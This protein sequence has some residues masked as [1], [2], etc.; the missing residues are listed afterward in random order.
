MHYGTVSASNK[1]IKKRFQFL[2]ERNRM[3]NLLGFYEQ[4]TI[5]KVLPLLCFNI[6]TNVAKDAAKTRWKLLPDLRAYVWVM[7]HPRLIMEKRRKI[8][9]I[10][11]VGDDEITPHMS[12]KL[13]SE[14]SGLRGLNGLSLAYCRVLGIRTMETR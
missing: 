9:S 3:L 1:L 14:K 4:K 5:A 8:Q 10:R 2:G 6:I 13:V 11:R 7:T 12:S